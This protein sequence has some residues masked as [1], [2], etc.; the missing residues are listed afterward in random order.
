MS[1]LQQ[2]R[3]LAAAQMEQK[4]V[5]TKEDVDFFSKMTS[6][7]DNACTEQKQLIDANAEL[8]KCYSDLAKHTTIGNQP[9]EVDKVGIGAA[10]SFE[11][12]LKQFEGK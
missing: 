9:K 1:Y 6:L 2:I 12:L 7:L 3:E 11:E 8:S 4:Q 10:P 5:K